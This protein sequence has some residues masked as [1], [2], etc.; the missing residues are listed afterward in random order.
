MSAELGAQVGLVAPDDDHARLAGARTARRDVDIAAWHSD[1]GAPGTRH[2]FDAVDAGA[3]G[4][5]AAQPGQRARRGR[6]SSPRAIDIAYIGACT[7]AKLDDLRAAARVLRGRRVARR[8]AAAGGAGQ[9]ARRGAGRSRRRDA[10][11]ARCR[12]RAAAQRLRRL[13][14]LR[15]PHSRRQH[16]D[17]DRPRATSRAAWAR[18]RRRCTW[19][20]PTPWPRRR[21]AARSAIARE[22][23]A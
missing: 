5:A 20:R 7:G 8:R 16:R 17:L 23:L 21:C 15:Q 14:R 18:P 11:A 10:R 13:R 6:R 3:A 2:D 9:R 1:A 12:R 22:L 19:L 4:R